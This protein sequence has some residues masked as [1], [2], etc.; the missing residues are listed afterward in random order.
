VVESAARRLLVLTLL[1]IGTS[2]TRATLRRVGAR[3][4]L[5]ATLLWLLVGTLTL[6]AVRA[7]V[8]A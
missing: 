1:L 8:V 7:G 4:L 3:P 2:L 5:Q 6:L